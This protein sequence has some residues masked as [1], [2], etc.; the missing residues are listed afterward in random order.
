MRHEVNEEVASELKK[1]LRGTAS[2]DRKWTLSGI[3]NSH[4]TKGQ[5]QEALTK[6]GWEE[7]AV[8]AL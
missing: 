3:P 1:L 5:V 2:S 6:I 4:A 7:S 8:D